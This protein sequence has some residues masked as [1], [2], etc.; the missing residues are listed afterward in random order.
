MVMKRQATPEERERRVRMLRAAVK[1]GCY[2]PDID[3]IAEAMLAKPLETF[4][5]SGL[6]TETSSS[7]I[8]RS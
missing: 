5:S 2:E 6:P 1:S 3:A 8:V 4:F 7:A